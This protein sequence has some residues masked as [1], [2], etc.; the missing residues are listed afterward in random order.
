ME[1]FSSSSSCRS[2]GTVSRA[3]LSWEQHTEGEVWCPDTPKNFPVH[4]CAT[5]DSLFLAASIP[6]LPV[7]HIYF[8]PFSFQTWAAHP[9][10]HRLLIKRKN[11]GPSLRRPTETLRVSPAQ[12]WRSLW[13]NHSMFSRVKEKIL[14]LKRLEAVSAAQVHSVLSAPLLF[15]TPKHP[16]EKHSSKNTFCLQDLQSFAVF[17][18]P[19][20]Q[21]GDLCK[22]WKGFIDEIK[23]EKETC[24]CLKSN[25][26]ETEVDLLS[27]AAK[28]FQRS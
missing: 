24:L 11:Q 1:M 4:A 13:M 12:L 8:Q 5:K 19:F 9:Q 10:V 21:Q 23:P 17:S 14:E 3:L 6:E 28:K 15:N 26:Q 22:W 27:G 16:T 25:C 2:S 18:T 20:S 7:F